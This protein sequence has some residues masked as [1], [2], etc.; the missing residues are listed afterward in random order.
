MCVYKNLKQRFLNKLVITFINL[1]QDF[2]LCTQIGVHTGKLGG[3]GGTWKLKIKVKQ[4]YTETIT[5]IVK[6][7]IYFYSPNLKV[8]LKLGKDSYILIE[9]FSEHLSVF[10]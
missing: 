4:T 6:S 9:Q 5:A 8:S 7:C 2:S 1:M 3:W 10:E